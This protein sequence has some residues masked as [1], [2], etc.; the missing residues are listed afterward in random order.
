M[1]DFEITPKM[2]LVYGVA[3]IISIS[4]WTLIY[5]TIRYIWRIIS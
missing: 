4:A 5:F 2:A 1:T 3:T